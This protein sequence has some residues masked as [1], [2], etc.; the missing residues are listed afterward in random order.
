MSIAAGAGQDV[1]AMSFSHF[2]SVTSLPKSPAATLRG[3]EEDS[4]FEGRRTAAVT[5]SGFV[6]SV[7]C[8]FAILALH[9]TASSYGIGDSSSE[10]DLI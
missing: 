4:L 6:S 3:R 7:G 10:V 5:L 9:Q 2:L 8:G 1:S